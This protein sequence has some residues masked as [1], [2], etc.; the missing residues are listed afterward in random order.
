MEITTFLLVS[1]TF[2]VAYMWFRRHDPKLPPCPVIPMP[3]FG[4]LLYMDKNPR[5]QFKQWRKK[6]GNIYSLYLG[7]NLVV[8][9]NGFDLVKEALVKNA[10]ITSDRP[11]IFFDAVELYL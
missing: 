6:C 10:D 11:Y 7:Q 8:V 5:A 2:L 4:H 9:L 1:L 3:V